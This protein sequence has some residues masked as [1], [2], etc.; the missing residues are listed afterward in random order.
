V[1]R[2]SLASPAPIV[3]ALLDWFDA[4]GRDW[5]WRRSRDRWVVLV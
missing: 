2:P 5:P 3:H 1:T 4:H